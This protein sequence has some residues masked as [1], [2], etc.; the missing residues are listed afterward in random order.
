MFDEFNIVVTCN[1]S[2]VLKYH[3]IIDGKE[4]GQIKDKGHLCLTLPKGP[5]TIF[6][7]NWAGETSKTTFDV[8]AEDLEINLKRVFGNKITIKPLTFETATKFS[9][10]IEDYY[11]NYYN[12]RQVDVL[13]IRTAEETNGLATYNY[14]IYSLLVI[15]KNGRQQ[16]LEVRDNSKRFE[17]LAPYIEKE[18][19]K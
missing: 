1:I 8:T 5:H 14:S 18:D 17:L 12:I 9:N 11:S 16:V 19:E 2:G 4:V 10:E 3:V 13:G 6:F 15:F 7:K